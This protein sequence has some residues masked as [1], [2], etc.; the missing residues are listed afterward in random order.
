MDPTL[1]NLPIKYYVLGLLVVQNGGAVLLM[2]AVR[3]LP[4]EKEF[5]TQ[6]AV[7]MQETLKACTCI[8]VLLYKH[9][10]LRPAFENRTEWLK[11]SVP[12][13]LY[14]VQNNL[15]YVAV[16]F[17]D[18][19]T[20]AVTYQ[21]KVFWVAVCS[22]L[23]LRRTVFPHQWLALAI[24]MSGV[25]AVQLNEQ[26][27]GSPAGGSHHSF[28]GWLLGVVVLLSAALCSSLAAVSFEKLLK[29]A[30][31]DMWTRNLQLAGFSLLCAGVPLLLSRD[32]AV[33]RQ[34]GFFHGYTPLTWACIFMNGW[35]GLLV[36]AV[37]KYANAILKDIAIGASICVSACGSIFF[38]DSRVTWNLVLGVLLVS[39]AV[40]LYAGR[41]HFGLPLLRPCKAKDAE[42]PSPASPPA[43][44]GAGL[45]TTSP[46]GKPANGAGEDK[47]AAGLRR[48]GRSAVGVAASM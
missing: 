19:A 34:K 17:L 37:I 16:G 31:A 2:R 3:A 26:R 11:T 9:K 15:Q 4:G 42:P 22:V 44:P 14:L 29:G 1:F 18:A 32:G 8:A 12:A 28:D 35:G 5:V 6:T 23:L 48:L 47:G 36:G 25:C 40:P 45:D 13:L 21:T 39:W 41:A 43:K 38:F 7:I 10:T 27:G 30:K 33:V 20:Y 46:N 24:L